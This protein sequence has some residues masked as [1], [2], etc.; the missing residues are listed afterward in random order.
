MNLHRLIADIAQ[1][2]L[3]DTEITDI[4]SDTRGVITAGTLFVCVAGKQFDAHTMAAELLA[5]GA[6]AV[7]VERD[8]GL[9]RQILVSDTREALSAL[10]AAFFGHPE[11]AFQLIGI[12]GTNGKTT[13]TTVLKEV[14]T[15]FGFKVGLIGTRQNE[16]GNEIFHTER[17]TPEPYELYA[18]FRK[19]ADAGC[20]YV[21]MEVSSQG[22]AQKRLGPCRFAAAAFTNLTQDHLD[23]HG[24]MEDYYQAK[25]LLFGLCDK[26][27]VNI[28]DAYGARL[29]DEITCEKASVSTTRKADFTAR[30]I[31]LHAGGA[32]Y[33]I[34]G[35]QGAYPVRF[36]IPGV[37]NVMNTAQV[38]AVLVQMGFALERA[39]AAVSVAH[40]VRGRAE[41]IPTGRDF[42]VLC[43]YAHTPDAIENIM[44]A[45]REVATGRVVCLFGCG[46]TRDAKKRPLMAQAA[47][48]H[49]D[50]L[51]LT[52]DNPR[53]EEPERILD[54]IEAGL[55]GV[56]VPYIKIT[57]R[58]EA[59][60]WAVN[61]AQKD[62]V[63]VLAGKGHEDYQI[64]AGG[65]KI[66]LDE[67]EIVAQALA[68]L[69]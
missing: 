36:G 16:I 40:G 67:R 33:T 12:T 62:D 27:A 53:D 20:D 10:C 22:L 65:V 41:V 1:T 46:G 64:L 13:I 7:V 15:G 49:S 39:A 34:A 29:F 66:H 58:I 25:K 9:E 21:V 6:A 50:F 44:T 11:R 37:F 42:T 68:G 45:V 17:T 54:E 2:T 69:N 8:L 57:D 30:D 60:H 18:L 28:D 23:V 59:I 55:S 61:N 14:L 47:A 48:R 19:M 3:P 5:K 56:T 31:R 24:T 26:A 32:D 38:L 63:I 35:V 51:I 43:D 52:S 4:V